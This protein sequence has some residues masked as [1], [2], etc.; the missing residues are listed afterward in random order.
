VQLQSLKQCKGY[1][2]L[3]LYKSFQDFS[4]IYKLSD[5]MPLII[6]KYLHSKSLINIWCIGTW[7]L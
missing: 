7:W 2:A 3:T 5:Q 4:L 1:Y 6:L